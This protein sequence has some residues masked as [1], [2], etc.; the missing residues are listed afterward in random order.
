MGIIMG[1]KSNRI[2]AFKLSIDLIEKEPWLATRIMSQ[3][4]ILRAEFMYSRR[5]IEYQAISMMF[6]ECPEA[7]VAPEYYWVIEDGY[8]Y[9]ER[10]L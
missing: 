1:Y 7:C 4:I 8:V 2:G 3:C 6:D 5:S 10:F 9:P